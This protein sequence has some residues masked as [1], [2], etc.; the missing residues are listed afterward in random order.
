M[1]SSFGDVV[2]GEQIAGNLFSAVLGVVSCGIGSS[3]SCANA[4]QQQGQ[5]KPDGWYRLRTMRIDCERGTFD[6]DGDGIRRQPLKGDR[7]KQAAVIAA[8]SCQP[9]HGQA[10]MEES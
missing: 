7:K 5:A 6:I 9:M 4:L 2:L 1:A 10:E 8:R 3:S